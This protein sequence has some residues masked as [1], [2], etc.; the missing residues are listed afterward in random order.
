MDPKK[1]REAYDRGAATA[2]SRQSRPERV[3][4]PIL[5][6]DVPTFAEATR[7]AAQFGR[8]T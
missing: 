2:A 3:M 8:T 6:G 1:V 5:H 7:R 4:A